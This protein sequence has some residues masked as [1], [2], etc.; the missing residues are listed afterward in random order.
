MISSLPSCAG[1]SPRQSGMSSSATF[2]DAGSRAAI[3]CMVCGAMVE[4]TAITLPSRAPLSTPRS[5]NITASTSWS[6]PTT[7]MT[8]SLAAA[9]ACGDS[10]VCDAG[11]RRLLHRV[12]ADVE[13]RDREAALHQVA[14]HRQAHLAEPD[15]A[16]AA[17]V[18]RCHGVFSLVRRAELR[19]SRAAWRAVH[20]ASVFA[21]T[22]P[23]QKASRNVASKEDHVKR[24]FATLLAAMLFVGASIHSMSSAA[25]QDWPNKPVRIV[26]T[27]A[28]GGAADYLAR[29]VADNLSTAFGQQF[30]VETRSGAAGAIGV[31]SVVATPPDGYNFVITNITML[32]L[33]P[34]SQSAARLSSRARPHQHRLSRRLAGR[35]VGQLRRATSRRSPISSPTGKKTGKPLTYSSSGVGSSGHLFGETFGAQGRDQGRACALQGRGAGPARSRRRPHHVVGA[36]RDVVGRARSAAARCAASRVTVQGAHGRLSRHADLRRARPRRVQHADLVLAVGA[37]RDCRRRS[38]TR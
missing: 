18:I 6:K 19:A 31:N 16:H 28:P 14:R 8:R 35:A 30:F 2:G 3:R 38:S 5:P 12:F 22:S 24:P 20:R 7:M 27:F 32:V 15:Q 33:A 25:A 1:P 36:D 11:F 23:I 4:A 34:I 13:A 26:N 29:T 17:D 10:A 9:T 37:R 21:Y